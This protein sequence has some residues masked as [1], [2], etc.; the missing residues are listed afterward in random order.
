MLRKTAKKIGKPGIVLAS[1][2]ALL[3]ASGFSAQVI[4]AEQQKI[5]YQGENGCPG[6]CPQPDDNRDR[7]KSRSSEDADLKPAS[8]NKP[9]IKRSRMRE[10]K[11]TQS[12]DAK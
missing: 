12:E 10:V 6:G 9:L 2:T 8:E 7:R 11:N 4:A 1:A 5:Q 3:L